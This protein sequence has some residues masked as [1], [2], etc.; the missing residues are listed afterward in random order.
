MKP[1]GSTTGAWVDLRG[2]V[3]VYAMYGWQSEGLSTRNEE[4][5]ETIWTS[6]IGVRYCWISGCDADLDLDE[7]S[8]ITPLQRWER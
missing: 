2:G 1:A 4:F 6:P 8:R 5:L 7:L 3:C